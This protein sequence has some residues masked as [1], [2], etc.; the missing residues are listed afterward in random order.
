MII[1][2]NT[3]NLECENDDFVNK[4]LSIVTEENRY[5]INIEFDSVI[6]V[7]PNLVSCSSRN[8]VQCINAHHFSVEYTFIEEETDYRYFFL[9]GCCRQETLLN[10]YQPDSVGLFTLSDF[11]EESYNNSN[12]SPQF[13]NPFLFEFCVGDSIS[14][15]VEA[16]DMDSDQLIYS[17]CEVYIIGDNY[18]SFFDIGPPFNTVQYILPTYSAEYPLGQGGL[19]ID[20]NTGELGGFPTIQGQFVVGIC[21][22]EYRNGVHLGTTRQDMIISVVPCTPLFEGDLASDE[23]T[24]DDQHVFYLCNE[25]ALTI[26]N[27]SSPT[28]NIVGYYWELS[29]NG[30]IQTSTDEHP[31]FY[32][33]EAGAYPG[34]MVINPDSTCT[35]TVHFEVRVSD[36]ETNFEMRYDTCDTGPVTFMASPT[37]SMLPVY[38]HFWDFGDQQLGIDSTIKH[39]YEQAGSYS[40]MLVI[41]DEYHCR[42]T[43][44]QELVW[45]PS[46][47]V[48]L[49]A[50]ETA[51]SCTPLETVIV[52][53]SRPVDSTYQLF[54]DFGDGTTATGLAPSHRYE[55]PGRYDVYLSVTSPLGCFIDTVFEDLIFADEPPIADFIW[56]PEHPTSLNSELT[57]ISDSERAIGWEWYFEEDGLPNILEQTQYVFADTGLQQVMLV[58]E[59]QYGCLDSISKNI[60]ILPVSTYF[61]PNAF[62]PNDD[63]KNDIFIGVGVTQYFRS[64]NLRVFNRWGQ[65]VFHSIDAQN[66]WNGRYQNSGKLAP[67]DVYTWQL[68]YTPSRG[69]VVSKTGQVVLMR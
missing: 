18:D 25:S 52:N 43:M 31:T 8:Y 55:I 46:P 42:D 5:Y 16:S 28:E 65:I 48:L 39:Q 54:W 29:T 7:Q 66:G 26:T 68:E 69:A 34:W 58:V 11:S 63:G 57:L 1:F 64:F 32:F 33:E 10:I 17:L 67:N 6:Q 24:A 61:L 27:L 19:S 23:I 35:D 44:A 30:M 60:D 51:A 22:D 41:E 4:T 49:V 37:S 15:E 56:T 36:I 14:A 2:L 47:D 59:D 3:P 13:S 20:P 38:Q 50:P 45:Q 21:V 12:S 53:R 9:I 40:V 62:T